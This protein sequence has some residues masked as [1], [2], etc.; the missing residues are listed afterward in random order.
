MVDRAEI[1]S[2]SSFS[3]AASAGRFPTRLS[4]HILQENFDVVPE[5]INVH[6]LQ[7]QSLTDDDDERG[8]EEVI[9]VVFKAGKEDDVEDEI[10]PVVAE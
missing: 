7:V 10:D 5:L 1:L 4:P 3:L 8:A 9:V 6:F 2:L